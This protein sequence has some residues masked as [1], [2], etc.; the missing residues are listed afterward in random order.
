MSIR[1][2]R[3]RIETNVSRYLKS[4][5]QEVL[6]GDFPLD[7]INMNKLEGIQAGIPVFNNVSMQ[8]IKFLLKNFSVLNIAQGCNNACSHSV[9]YSLRLNLF[10]SDILTDVY[11]LLFLLFLSVMVCLNDIWCKLNFN[12]FSFLFLS[13]Y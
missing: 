1:I 12:I 10:D 7:K 2:P 3:H 8:E 6:S 9:M 13:N 5:P 4:L 11:C